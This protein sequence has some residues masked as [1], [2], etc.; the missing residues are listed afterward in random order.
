MTRILVVD[1]E[2][3]IVDMIC[4]YLRSESFLVE[5]ISNPVDTFKLLDQLKP[6]LIVL[7]IM[8]SPVNGIDILK[9]IRKLSD[10]P[11]ILLTARADEVDK[12]LGLELGAD[13]YITK[14]FSLRELSARIR[15]V[16]RRATGGNS[17]SPQPLIYGNV[18]LDSI[19]MDVCCNGDHVF[20][21]RTEFKILES[22]ISHPGRVFTRLQLLDALGEAYIGYERTLDTHVS[23]LRKKLEKCTD[24]EFRILTVYGIG[25]KLGGL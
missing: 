23:N 24:H 21:T 19:Q 10:L 6:D 18:S 9:E 15:V 17:I 7:D 11:I 1:D 25:Y 14:P 20:L 2:P 3:K 8:M 16:L 22:L 4:S 12:L 13:D 5:G